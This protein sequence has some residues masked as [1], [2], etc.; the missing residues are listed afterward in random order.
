MRLWKEQ[1]TTE[2]K[3]EFF[4]FEF[5][6]PIVK[7]NQTTVNFEYSEDKESFYVKGYSKKLISTLLIFIGV[8]LTYASSLTIF[9]V[10]VVNSVNISKPSTTFLVFIIGLI[11]TVLGVERFE[12]KSYYLLYLSIPFVSLILGFLFM[13]TP[14]NWH[15]KLFGAFSLF[16]FPLVLFIFY[17]LKER[18]S[19]LQFWQSSKL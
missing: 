11:L 6:Q 17:Y 10:F 13:L 9:Q 8:Y 18:L 5:P 3:Q 2:L 15:G 14:T 4:D 16:F 7:K 1:S 19:S 12:K